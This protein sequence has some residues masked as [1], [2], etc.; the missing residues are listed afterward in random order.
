MQGNLLQ[1]PLPPGSV[2]LL[3][4]SL[5]LHQL[6]D[7][8]QLALFQKIHSLL[9]DDGEMVFA[10]EL[11]LFDPEAEPERF[12]RVYRY[13][14]A[15]T[16]PKDVYEQQI[17]PYLTDGYVYTW[18]D[19][20]ANTPPEFWFHTLPHLQTKLHAANLV[21]REVKELTLF[22]GLCRVTKQA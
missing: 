5:M 15:N 19:M 11:I 9:K 13:L 17:K 20:K 3:V 7:E 16:T 22:F 6:S 2:D 4:S 8:N 14:L 21:L 18:Q 1:L 12:N 10:D